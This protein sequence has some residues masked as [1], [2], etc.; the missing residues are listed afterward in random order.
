MMI[1]SDV[2]IEDNFD[3]NYGFIGKNIDMRMMLLLMMMGHEMMLML[4]TSLRWD[5]V[6]DDNVIEMRWCW[7]WKWH[8]EE[9]MPML[10]MILRLNIVDVENVIVMC[11]YMGGAVTMMDIPGGGNRVVKKF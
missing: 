8:W 11:M 7:C 6:D 2:V 9:M 4:I 1:W 10:A 5:D 3:K